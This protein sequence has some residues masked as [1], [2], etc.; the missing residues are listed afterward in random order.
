[1]AQLGENFEHFAFEGVVAPCHADLARKVPEV[2]S[3]S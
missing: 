1:M 3:L 2:G